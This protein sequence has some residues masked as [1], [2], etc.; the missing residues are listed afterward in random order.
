MAL[1]LVAGADVRSS[2]QQPRQVTIQADQRSHNG[3][4]I[5]RLSSKTARPTAATLRK[6]SAFIQLVHNPSDVIGFGLGAQCPDLVAWCPGHT[7]YFKRATTP[8]RLFINFLQRTIN[9][10]KLF[11][12]QAT[13]FCNVQKLVGTFQFT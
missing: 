7:I 4:P 11:R 1:N 5:C 8:Q 12:T 13:K 10:F 6:P 3:R 9:H 2:G